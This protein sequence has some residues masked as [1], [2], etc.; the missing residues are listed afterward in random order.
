M[1]TRVEI[2]ARLDALQVHVHVSSA[3]PP[4]GCKKRN[5]S[6]RGTC[7]PFRDGARHLAAKQKTNGQTRS[8]DWLIYL[9]RVHGVDA[10][11]G[12]VEVGIRYR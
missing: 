9:P 1:M 2:S 4:I 5:L 6:T 12:S 11:G 3:R 7:H 10:L 8:H